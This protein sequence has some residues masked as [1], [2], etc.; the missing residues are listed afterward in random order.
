MTEEYAI[1]VV[2]PIL[3]TLSLDA[4]LYSKSNR[5]LILADHARA[6]LVDHLLS[7]FC[8]KNGIV[9]PV[10]DESLTAKV[11]LSIR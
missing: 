3:E 5:N 1:R 2:S 8:H 4:L 6:E 11:S 10:P 7:S 9:R